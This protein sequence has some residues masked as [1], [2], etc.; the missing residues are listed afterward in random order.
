MPP[1]GYF[2]LRYRTENNEKGDFARRMFG[3]DW[4]GRLPSLKRKVKNT[5]DEVIL[6]A[7]LD[8]WN[9]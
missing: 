6:E 8:E 1:F 5:D 9:S 3:S 2:L 4:D 7:I